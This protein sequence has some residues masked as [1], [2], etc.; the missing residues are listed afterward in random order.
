MN[1]LIFLSIVAFQLVVSVGKCNNV[2]NAIISSSGGIYEAGNINLS[3]TLGDIAVETI[4]NRAVYLT[5]GFQQPFIEGS[6]SNIEVENNENYDIKL[7]PNPAKDILNVSISNDLDKG[8]QMLIEIIDIYG[9]RVFS[10]TT[11][12]LSFQLDIS[13]LQSNLYLLQIRSSNG[14]IIDIQKFVKKY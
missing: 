10:K 4:H 6:T 3:W 5:Q 12:S 13:N 2:D 11:G 8:G 9:R 14:R 1:R 7:Y